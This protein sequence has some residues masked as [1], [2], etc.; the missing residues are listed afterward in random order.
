[1]KDN[2]QLL[3]YKKSN[4]NV[5]IDVRLEDENV[6][7]TQA[8]MADLYQVKPQNITMHLKNIY[9]EG[10]LDKEATCKSFLQVQQEGIQ[11]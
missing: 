2:S 9:S 6:W 10:E 3:I 11:F 8:Q 1:M 4:G 5:T 7:L